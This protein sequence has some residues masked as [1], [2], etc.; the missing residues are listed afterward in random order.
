MDQ[1]IHLVTLTLIGI[2]IFYASIMVWMSSFT[3]DRGTKMKIAFAWVA[4]V[5]AF[6]VIL[7]NPGFVPGVLRSIPLPPNPFTVSG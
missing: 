2:A 4:L 7:Y 1:F 5:V 6:F 3:P